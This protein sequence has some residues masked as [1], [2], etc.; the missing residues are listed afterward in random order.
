MKKQ[1]SLVLI[2]LFVSVST[3]ISAS[4]VVKFRIENDKDQESF[5]TY[6]KN[7]GQLQKT[8]NQEDLYLLGP[9]A[10]VSFDESRKTN[11]AKTTLRVRTEQPLIAAPPKVSAIL[12]KF[13][14][15]SEGYTEENKIEVGV[16]NAQDTVKLF[17]SLGFS[18]CTQLKTNRFEY[19]LNNLTIACDQI[20]SLGLF[21]E[22]KPD[23]DSSLFKNKSSVYNFIKNTG[24]K[25]IR[26]FDRDP[27]HILWNASNSN[28]KIGTIKK[29]K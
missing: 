19:T 6:L 21:F 27:I 4:E 25:E 22:V 8:I 9:A 10:P 16:N 18:R 7:Y 3:R 17:M 5:T 1:L 29:L 11:D 15:N 13:Y 28:H 20:E 12:K 2:T 23:E 26:E 24:V 14:I